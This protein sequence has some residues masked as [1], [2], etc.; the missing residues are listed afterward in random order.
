[1]IEKIIKAINSNYVIVSR[2]GKEEAEVD[3]LSI[4]EINLSV[5]KGEIIEDYP[6]DKRGHSCLIYGK[7]QYSEPIHSVWGYNENTGFAILITV[8][9][10]NSLEWIDNRIRK[11]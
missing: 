10:P 3:N 4:D 9:R 2:H 11:K 5:I 7:N 1:M 6:D 8:Y